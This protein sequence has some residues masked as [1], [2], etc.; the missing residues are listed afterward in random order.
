M[1]LAW[2]AIAVAAAL[3]VGS[4]GAHAQRS[5]SIWENDA[6]AKTD[7]DYTNGFRQSFVFDDFSRDLFAAKVFEFVKPGLITLGAPNASTRQQIEWIALA[8]SIFTPDHVS[9]PVRAPGD[10]PFG[11]WLYTGFNASQETGRTQL[12][13]FEVLIGAVGGSA[14]LATEVQ[15]GFHQLL[16]Q[17][18]P[19]I[20]GYELHNEPGFLLAWDRRW[21]TG[22]DLGNGYGVDLIPSIGF[23][24]GNVFTYGSAGAIARFGQSL[25]TT[26]GPTLVRPAPSGASFISPNPDAPWWGFDFFG[27][28]EARGVVRNIFLDGNTFENSISVTRKP[29]VYDLLAGAEIFTQ[30]GFVLSG[31]VIRRSREYTTQL[32]PSTFGSVSG[33]FRF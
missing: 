10:R 26:W 23:T 12:D 31:T 25:S 16:G 7:R 13:S 8:Q 32:K 20:N 4:A 30:T 29:F 17:R 19:V 22:I 6:V 18:R 21:K 33:S 27:G 28:A 9:N 11:G 2:R 5:I 24:G 3:V 1:R 14:S 15:G